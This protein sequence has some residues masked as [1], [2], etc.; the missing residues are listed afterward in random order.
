MRALLKQP[1]EGPDMADRDFRVRVLDD[2]KA[3]NLFGDTHKPPILI[4]ER[5]GEA[6]LLITSQDDNFQISTTAEQGGSV[7]PAST[8]FQWGSSTRR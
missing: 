3:E 6:T 4:L 1:D 8:G 7:M 2:G 5:T